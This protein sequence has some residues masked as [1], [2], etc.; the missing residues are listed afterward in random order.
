MSYKKGLRPFSFLQ[1]NN[2]VTS[3]CVEKGKLNGSQYRF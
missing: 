2:I 1:I 3:R